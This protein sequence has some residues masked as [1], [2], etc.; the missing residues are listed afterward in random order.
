M[1]G[2]VTDQAVW[3]ELQRT[4]EITLDIVKVLLQA[5]RLE[6]NPNPNPNP[7]PN[8]GSIST[9]TTTTTTTGSPCSSS[10]SSSGSSGS[11]MLAN[12]L[13]KKKNPREEFLAEAFSVSERNER[14][15]EENN[16][17]Q[18]TFA[19]Q[20]FLDMNKECRRLL[21]D[22]LLQPRMFSSSTHVYTSTV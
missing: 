7:N 21:H 17:E 6:N 10:S 14:N 18:T 3:N 19:D 5:G 11:G 16:N 1:G 12:K 9:T 20:E 22:L 15:E 2:R 4:M 13:E 8:T